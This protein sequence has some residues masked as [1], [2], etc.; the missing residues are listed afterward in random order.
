MWTGS[1]VKIEEKED[2]RKEKGSYWWP[3]VDVGRWQ[4]DKAQDDLGFGLA[5]RRS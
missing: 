5:A 1:L 2:R 4:E 3:R